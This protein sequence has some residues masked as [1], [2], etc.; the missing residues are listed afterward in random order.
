[1]GRL[2]RSEQMLGHA[3][4][5]RCL[6]VRVMKASARCFNVRDSVRPLSALCKRCPNERD[7]RCGGNCRGE[8]S[9]VKPGSLSGHYRIH[10]PQSLVGSILSSNAFTPLLRARSADRS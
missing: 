2:G 1:M 3:C 7:L 8:E 5:A 9:E 4:C 10:T 6:V